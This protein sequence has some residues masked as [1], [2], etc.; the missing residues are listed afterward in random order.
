MK[1]FLE[2]F[3]PNVSVW[4]LTK[5]FPEYAS[6][7]DKIEDLDEQVKKGVSRQVEIEFYDLME[8][9]DG[10]LLKEENINKYNS[11]F[12]Q[13]QL[14]KDLL[15]EDNLYT[16]EE[17][18]EILES[19]ITDLM[20]EVD[21]KIISAQ[22]QSDINNVKKKKD[23]IV[24]ERITKD[25]LSPDQQY[26]GL[27]LTQDKIRKTDLEKG[28]DIFQRG[29]KFKTLTY[30]N[31]NFIMFDL[32]GKKRIIV[33]TPEYT[34]DYAELDRARDEM[35]LTYILAENQE[36]LEKVWTIMQHAFDFDDDSVSKIDDDFL[37]NNPVIYGS[38]QD[39]L[40]ENVSL[41]RQKDDGLILRQNSYREYFD[42]YVPLEQ[43]LALTFCKQ[44]FQRDGNFDIQQNRSDIYEAIKTSS[45]K[46]EGIG[47]IN[48]SVNVLDKL[49]EKGL[50]ENT[51][52]PTPKGEGIV[53]LNSLGY[54]TIQYKFRPFMYYMVNLVEALQK[55]KNVIVSNYN[56][57][58]LYHNKQRIK[59]I[60]F[61][62]VLTNNQLTEYDLKKVKKEE[63][64]PQ[65]WQANQN[66][67]EYSEYIPFAGDGGLTIKSRDNT[68]ENTINFQDYK[69]FDLYFANVDNP[70]MVWGL[71]SS[72]YNF[73]KNMY[74]DRKIKV[75]GRMLMQGT[76]EKNLFFHMIDENDNLLAILR[77]LGSKQR[78]EI[79]QVDKA[80][81]R[82]DTKQQEFKF[83]QDWKDLSS[84]NYPAPVWDYQK[85]LQ[86]ISEDNGNF[87]KDG[88]FISEANVEGSLFDNKDNVIVQGG[89]WEEEFADA[90]SF[91]RAQAQ[92]ED[93]EEVREN[94][95]LEKLEP[96]VE[97]NKNNE[98]L[99]ELYSELEALEEVLAISEDDED[100][101]KEIEDKKQEIVNLKSDSKVVVEEEKEEQVE[102]DFNKETILNDIESD[103]KSSFP[104]SL[105]AQ[106]GEVDRD[107]DEVRYST[108]YL[109]NWSLPE[110]V[111]EDDEDSQ[112][113][114]YE[115][116]DRD[117]YTKFS[118][119]FN[120]WVE[121]KD[122]AKY[123][124]TYMDPSEKNWLDFSVRLK[125]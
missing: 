117:D 11:V 34:D 69:K 2:T 52:K 15:E 80:G 66:F 25:M 85:I 54:R 103:F 55:S 10:F 93:T 40:Y 87:V 17:A 118:K 41:Y 106:Q 82:V 30:T 16:E 18:K 122:W 77:P 13:R 83:T 88:I 108:R 27:S 123:V 65:S 64:F 22:T 73:V 33:Q 60:D 8:S 37:Y 74:S 61:G 95:D 92:I 32:G 19:E 45:F 6:V 57:H 12:P 42:L 98:E 76:T 94:L 56:G 101:K 110:D 109:G 63:L 81:L 67:K 49:E 84:K 89:D 112:D 119:K 46:V 59:D 116:L 105:K 26:V 48:T 38:Y 86:D 47:V 107:S 36:E 125:K 75:M 97:E 114:D 90:A 72:H 28:L 96:A 50:V 39:F 44:I 53:F 14:D 79:V 111:D 78:T 43:I 1:K 5:V 104:S 51:Y 29:V 58:S 9:L 20:K 115:E 68:K 7:F 102:E 91:E 62:L 124:D 71:N 23:N 3:S 31:K 113:Y 4:N 120:D 100:I 70:Y 21:E 24:Q 121:T 35:M 99:T